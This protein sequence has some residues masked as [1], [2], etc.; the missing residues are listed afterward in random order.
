MK[1]ST[2]MR[3]VAVVGGS[4]SGKTWL[5]D[6]LQ[7]SVGDGVGRLSLDDFYLDRSHL[8][9]AQ[10]EKINFDHPSAIDWPLVEKSL[11]ACRAGRS[12][13]VPRYDFTS[14]TRLPCCEMFRPRPLNIVE[15]LWLLLR[16][17]VRSFFALRIFIECPLR[18]RLA[19]RL[20]RDAAERG[21]S[22]E[23]VRKQFWETVAPMHERH[24]APQARWAHFVL[25][26]P[27]KSDRVRQLV[28][29]LQTL[30]KTGKD[31]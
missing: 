2:K 3:L 16:P 23:S 17:P 31:L 29:L 21:R 25:E 24:V 10:R 14:H 28:D 13:R 22:R 20:N 30:K 6:H 9:A 26:S 8:P 11:K 27:P 15:G 12:F 19:R 1:S 7:K 5:A 18:V 4:G